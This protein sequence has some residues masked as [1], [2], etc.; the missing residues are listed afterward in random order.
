[1]KLLEPIVHFIGQL[2][3]R[4]K[5]R[6]TALIFG[7]PLLAVTGVL[8]TGITARV[9]ALK[10]ER[11]ALQIQLPTLALLGNLYQ[12]SAAADGVREGGDDLQPL[13]QKLKDNTLQTLERLQDVTEDQGLFRN[14]E[15]TNHKWLGRW[16]AISKQVSEG[17]A[18]D[19][20]QLA[21]SLHTELE[22]A[23]GRYGLLSDGDVSGSR[24]LEVVTN[25]L[26]S[27]VETTG[28]AAQIGTV[29]LI[30]Q[31]VRG[32]RRSELTL[33]RGNFDALL[34][35]TIDTLRK[36]GSEQPGIT[37]KLD[38]ASSQLNTAY[39]SLQEAITIKMLDT[40]DYGMAPA[41]YLGISEKALGE[42]LAAGNLLIQAAD[43]LLSERLALL[44]IQRNIVFAAIL[45]TSLFV[46]A[47]FIAAYI[48]IMRG[49]NGLSEA[50]ET[51]AKG[52][53]DAR[54][55][56]TSRDE[57]GDVGERFNEMAESLALRTSELREKTNDIH[58]M[59]K[60][61]PQ[62]ILTIVGEGKIHSEYSAYLETIFETNALSGRHA[63]DL[64]TGGSNIGVDARAQQEASLSACLG[65]D[66]INFEFNAH[67]LPEEVHKP[68]AD[69]RIKILEMTWAPICDDFDTVEKV[70]VCVRDVTDIRRLQA[71]SEHQKLE[72]AMIGQ[73]LKVNQ[74]KFHEFIDGAR[75]FVAENEKLL[76]ETQF[77]SP[78]W[79]GQLFRNMHTVKGNART[80][81]L[82][83][84][85][86][87]VHEAEQAYDLLRTTN[88][89]RFDKQA[90][91]D[92][93]GDV[94]RVLEEYAHLN[95]I[96]LG[97]K[98]PGRRGSADKYLMLDRLQLE[99]MI[100]QLAAYDLSACSQ[101]TL[102]A[103]LAQV[104]QDL[105]LIGTEP[106]LGVLDG[107]FDSLPSLAK[108]LGKEAPNLV[109]V[110][111]GIHVRNQVSNLLSNV[112][113][114]L[115]RNAMDHGIETP[116]ERH[117]KNKPS[118]GTIQLDVELQADKLLLRLTDD[119]RGLALKHIR[120]RAI[121][122]GL[123][124]EAQAK[125]DPIV[126]NLIFAAGFSTATQVTAISGRGVGMDAVQDFVKREGG[127]ICLHLMDDA[128]G[129]EFRRFE[130]L[131]SLPGSLA[132]EAKSAPMLGGTSLNSGVEK[133]NSQSTVDAGN[134][135]QLIPGFGVA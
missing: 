27:L 57:L 44:Q 75:H 20:A 24:L 72:L 78:E 126:A 80:Y 59:L 28:H 114:H 108:E 41:A 70:M 91:L 132:V 106:I 129:A 93:L 34:L 109:V 95:E 45:L 128:V 67:L 96:K 12:L 83:Y 26:P 29:V 85:T 1:M 89:A 42:T 47:A 107:V 77:A 65:E 25:H 31:S 111:N 133:Q 103:A 56:V 119:G 3:F 53:L 90:L 43:M 37:G 52:N 104:Q 76:T 124:D 127:S 87:V 66:V 94:S 92:Q 100:S 5:L 48:S 88:N 22:A 33:M 63:L 30:K 17:E 2:S 71:E 134:S 36:V 15:V 86:N 110:D 73:I 125:E 13:V 38:E 121:E 18:D 102:A 112:F 68:M 55:N 113:M 105:R 32:S 11:V 58:N 10:Q 69:G 131:I 19:I 118:S 14:D 99:T 40:T 98:G 21:N 60:N 97:R 122:K 130:T 117:S 49:L 16:N 7:I 82:L 39:S 74:E 120:Q 51:M 64:L 6:G 79:V 46:L 62:G 54:V 4:N 35:W 50:V 84:L 61:L 8:L 115:Y 9:D 81:G 135:I 101:A 23:N 116:A 123:I